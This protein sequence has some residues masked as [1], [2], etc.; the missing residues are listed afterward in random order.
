MKYKGYKIELESG[1]YKVYTRFMF[2]WW[3]SMKANN[4][5]Y[6]NFKREDISFENIEAAENFIDAIEYER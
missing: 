6:S 5:L 3:I 4:M 1:V 2:F